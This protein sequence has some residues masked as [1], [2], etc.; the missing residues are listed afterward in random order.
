MENR[1]ANRRKWGDWQLDEDDFTLVLQSGGRH[2]EIR[3]E[4]ISNSA[5][6]LE[7]ELQLR[8][9][10]WVTIDI[11]ADLVSAFLDLL[12]SQTTR[13]GQG[14]K[15]TVDTRGS[16]RLSSPPT[17]RDAVRRTVQNRSGAIVALMVRCVV[18]GRS[19]LCLVAPSST[20]HK[21]LSKLT[22]R[23][24]PDGKRWRPTRYP[25]PQ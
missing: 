9:K 6:M 18:R 11:I 8:T 24:N 10:E 2:F 25:S 4:D 22:A 15:A 16:V 23:R 20:F 1:A 19:L 14:F 13:Y 17:R 3:L 21:V 5:K 7:W 12:G